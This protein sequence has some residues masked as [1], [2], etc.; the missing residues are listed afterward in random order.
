[1]AHQEKSDTLWPDTPER[2]I[3]RLISLSI[4]IPETT[5]PPD[6]SGGVASKPATIAASVSGQNVTLQLLM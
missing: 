4:R 2:T 3:T 1:M 6:G 5:T